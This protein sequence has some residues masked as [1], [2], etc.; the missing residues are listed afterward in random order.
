MIKDESGISGYKTKL[1]NDVK[2]QSY[3]DKYDKNV[4]V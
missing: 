3:A 2:I 1:N 4:F